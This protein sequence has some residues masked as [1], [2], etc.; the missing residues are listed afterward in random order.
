MYLKEIGRIPLLSSE[1]EIALCKRIEQGDIEAK[2]R[3]AEA[4]LRLVVSI[5]KRYTNRGMQFLDLIQEGNEGLLKAIDKFDY[6]KGFKFSTYAT[7]WIRQAITRGIADQARTIRIPVHMVEKIKKTFRVQRTLL[8]ILGREPT[9][10][11]IAE[12]MGLTPTEIREILKY[13]TEPVSLETPVGEDEDN[14]LGDFVAD[15][16]IILPEN[17]S[18]TENMKVALRSVL[19][20]LT[21]REQKVLA[22]RFGLEDGRAR[23]LEE[24]SKYFDVTRERIRQIEAKALKKL[25]HPAKAKRIKDYYEDNFYKG[26]K[27]TLKATTDSKNWEVPVQAQSWKIEKKEES[28]KPKP[29]A[30]VKR[31]I[32]NGAPIPSLLP[33]S[34]NISMNSQKENK[35][36]IPS[37][38]VST[39]KT[40]QQNTRT[41]QTK[42]VSTLSQTMPKKTSVDIKNTET[43]KEKETISSPLNETISKDIQLVATTENNAKSINPPLP[44]IEVEEG[45][46]NLNEETKVKIPQ[47]NSS[48]KIALTEYDYKAIE[49]RFGLKDGKKRTTVEISKILGLSQPTISKRINKAIKKL[50]SDN[51]IWYEWNNDEEK[52]EIIL[53]STKGNIVN[54]FFSQFN[55]YA[56]E[57]V[58]WALVFI[59]N[60]KRDVTFVKFGENLDTNLPW[61]KDAS[62]ASY[63]SAT[64]SCAKKDIQNILDGNKKILPFIKKYAKEE[65]EPLFTQLTKEELKLFTLFHGENYDELKLVSYDKNHT[66]KDLINAYLELTAKLETKIL[67]QRKY[68]KSKKIKNETI[69]DEKQ[70][71]QTKSFF[72]NF[73]EY[74]Q[75]KIF[76]AFLSLRENPRQTIFNRHGENL[77]ELNKLDKEGNSTTIPN[78]YN[79]IS[80]IKERLNGKILTKSFIKKYPKEEFMPIL[81]ILTQEEL[82]IFTLFHGENYDEH[83]MV[84][85]DKNHTIKD[86]I[87]AYLELTVKLETKILENRKAC[88]YKKNKRIKLTKREYEIVELRFGLKDGKKRSNKEVGE[89]LGLKPNSISVYISTAIQKLE[90]D[91]SIWLEWNKDNKKLDIVLNSKKIRITSGHLVGDYFFSQFEGNSKEDVLWALS[92]LRKNPRQK[93]Y[94]RHGKNLNELIKFDEDGKPTGNQNYYNTIKQ[95]KKRLAT[96]NNNKEFAEVKC[97]FLE[98]LG[99]SH[100]VAKEAIAMLPLEEKK[101]MYLRRGESL[102]EFNPFPKDKSI[103]IYKKLEEDAIYHTKE[104]IRII[105]RR[106]NAEKETNNNLEQERIQLEQEKLNL[107]KASL[108][109]EIS[110][111]FGKL[112]SKEQITSLIDTIVKDIN[113]SKMVYLSLIENQLFLDL[114]NFYHKIYLF[115]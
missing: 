99:C 55:G 14:F 67:E 42:K 36:D 104:N 50:E 75:E 48:K 81:S 10:E 23:T 90:S 41:K 15:E 96:K 56:K 109:E 66:I 101:L 105:K 111:T 5:A 19:E 20:E 110:K 9:P 82:E 91:N 76:W 25:R 84:T 59:A 57:N 92:N 16:N 70:A 18:L 6:K 100:E 2:K 77:N 85:Y 93:I 51:S 94:N 87:N 45:L 7:W 58:F 53:N 27:S 63:Y 47:K 21:E 65:F 12:E 80:Q 3:L 102:L 37:N 38:A 73:E 64:F 68:C 1:E 62:C 34:T 71:V 24:V 88:K 33:K 30:F 29:M 49:L 8:Q 95:I 54:D 89:V 61:P 107:L 11:E 108:F 86:L 40:E 72:S 22:L 74:S 106:Q 79:A 114:S 17:Y 31:P 60:V 4:N 112:V 13:A 98:K 97:D 103:P 46:S 113:Q 44:K 28:E 52:L 69:S 83:K 32:K 26:E 39:L 43:S 115:F 78:Y 35:K